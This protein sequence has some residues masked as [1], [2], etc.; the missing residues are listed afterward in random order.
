[1]AVQC[2]FSISIVTTCNITVHEGVPDHMIEQ[3]HC[4]KKDDCLCGAAT[5]PRVIVVRDFRL[6][7]QQK[8]YRCAEE[9]YV[10]PAVFQILA[11]ETC[12]ERF[13]CIL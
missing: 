9:G 10:S 6:L 7:D 2:A 8:R 11:R 4:I 1:M 3:E 12:W 5:Q 13:L